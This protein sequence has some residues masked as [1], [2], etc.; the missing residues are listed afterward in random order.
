MQIKPSTEEKILVAQ[1]NEITEYHIYRKLV[2]FIGDEHN[3]DILTKIAEDELSHYQFWKEYSEQ[4][5]T[6]NRLKVWF[7]Y[8]VSVVFGVTFGIKLMERGE[9]SAQGINLYGH[10]ISSNCDAFDLSLLDL[11]RLLPMSCLNPYNSCVYHFCI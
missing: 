11:F 5:V 8:L 4:E 9:E 3:Q 7:Y 10:R 1:R 2:D 6:P